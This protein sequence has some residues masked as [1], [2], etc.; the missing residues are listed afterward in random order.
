MKNVP[1]ALVCLALCLALVS[2]AANAQKKKKKPAAT[3]AAVVVSPMEPTLN[4][5]ERVSAAT[6]SD[7]ADLK[8]EKHSFNWKTAWRFWHHESSHSQKTLEIAGSI[9]RNLHDALPGLVQDVRATGSFSATFKLYNDLTVL[10][11]LL[12]SLVDSTKAEGKKG[13]GPLANDSVAM[14]RIRQDLATFIEQKAAALDAT[15]TPPYTWTSVSTPNGTVKKIVVDDNV[16]EKK[17][18]RKTVAVKEQ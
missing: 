3:P 17:P 11:G 15:G 5:L 13:D 6:Q 8:A 18:S 2:P 14:G 4:D 9:Q 12:D 16:P 7:L 1:V 10:C